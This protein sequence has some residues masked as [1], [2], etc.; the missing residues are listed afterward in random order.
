VQ[1]SAVQCSAVLINAVQCSPAGG[2]GSNEESPRAQGLLQSLSCCVHCSAVHC[3]A[4]CTVHCV[5]CSAVCTVHCVHCSCVCTVHCDWDCALQCC[6]CSRVSQEYV[7]TMANAVRIA[8]KCSMRMHCAVCF[9][10]AG[11]VLY[12][13]HCALC[14]TM[15]TEHCA[16]HRAV[17]PV[18]QG[19][20]I[21]PKLYKGI[22]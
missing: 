22:L 2:P 5:H 6:V 11:T 12:T 20:C 1:C 21:A 18:L 13:E 7:P 19:N 10:L 9:G 15:Y 14:T 3:S 16:V 8:V 17:Q 4:V